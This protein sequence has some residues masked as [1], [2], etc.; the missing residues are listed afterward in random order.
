MHH[1]TKTD[2]GQNWGKLKKEWRFSQAMGGGGSA[3]GTAQFRRALRRLDV[4][5]S[6]EAV[7]ATV[8]MLDPE[9]CY[10]RAFDGREVRR[11]HFWSTF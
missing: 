1:F 7:A 8:E 6:D 2:S 4:A 9:R 5:A 10:F 3:V 11:R